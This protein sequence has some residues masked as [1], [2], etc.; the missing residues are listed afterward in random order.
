MRATCELC[1]HEGDDVR[2][3]LAWYKR[4]IAKRCGMP[5]VQTALR[6]LDSIACRERCEGNGDP[7]PLSRADDQWGRVE[8]AAERFRAPEPMPVPAA[9]SADEEEAPW[10]F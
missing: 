4:E 7:W 6:C 9:S 10:P 3:Q 2:V 8:Q 5:E 1:G